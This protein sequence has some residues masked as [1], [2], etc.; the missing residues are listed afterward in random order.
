LA[1]SR[2]RIE[3]AIVTVPWEAVYRLIETL[4]PMLLP[5]HG[6]GPLAAR[7]L[8]LQ[9]RPVPEH[10]I[11]EDRAAATANLVAPSLLARVRDAYDGPLL[12]LK[13]PEVAARYPD[14]ARR[15]GDL[16]LLAGDAQAAHAALLAAGFSLEDREWPPPGY[17]NI[18]RPHYHLHPLEWA[19]FALRIEIHQH[20]KW[21]GGL[22]PPRNEDLFEAAAPSS[23]GVEGLLAPHPNHHAIL[24]ASHAWGEIPMRKLRELVDVLVFVDDAQR[25]ELARLARRWQF[26]RA[27]NATLAAADWVLGGAPEPTFV[28]I[29]ARYL[30]NLREPTVVEMHLQEWLSPFWLVPPR[31]AIRRTGMAFVRE[32][33]PSPEQTW[34]D[35]RSQT[36]EALLHPLSPKSAHHR[37]SVAGRRKNLKAPAQGTRNE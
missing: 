13:G 29:W 33:R 17:D 9:G 12:L 5:E 15:F 6:L 37:R 25:G 3:E 24:L 28:R 19:G 4:D 32:L 14:R 7:R 27:W 31:L 2:N 10:L 34:A 18:H 30:R 22:T 21:P 8:R 1:R 35:K 23:V 26:D 11:R 16:D 36:V 20:V